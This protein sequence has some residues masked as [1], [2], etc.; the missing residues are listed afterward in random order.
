MHSAANILVVDDD[1]DLRAAVRTVLE[2]EGY[3][4]EEASG[5]G[6]AMGLLD[7][8]SY[9]LVLL[10]IALQDGSGFTVIEFMKEKQLSSRIIM[11]TGTSG[12]ENALRSVELGAED[13]VTK[14]FS[15]NYLLKAIQHALSLN[16]AKE[17]LEHS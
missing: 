17:D 12:L 15:L 8:K 2:A 7:G 13:Y 14:P 16:G 6:I 11:M 9:D 5:S 1:D 4:V 3:S 10:D